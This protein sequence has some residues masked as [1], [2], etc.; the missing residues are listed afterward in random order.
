MTAA[1]RPFADVRARPGLRVVQAALLLYGL[2]FIWNTSFVIGSHRVFCLFEDAMISM[3][4]ARNFSK[5]AGLVWNPGQAPVEGYTN[6]LWTLL[7]VPWHWM[8]L[9][10]NFTS[11][12]VQ[13]TA[14]ACLLLNLDVTVRVAKGVGAGGAAALFALLCTAFYLPILNWSL[15][16]METG[17]LM[18]VTSLACRRGLEDLAR[19]RFGFA[20]YGWL[21][22]GTLIR[23]DAL[24]MLL[25]CGLLMAALDPARRGRRLL[26]AFGLTLGMAALQAGLR[27]WYYGQALPNTYYLKMTGF[28]VGLR[29]LRGASVNGAFLLGLAWVVPAV[30]LGLLVFRE[31]RS[32]FLP[33]GMFMVQLLYSVYVGGDAWEFWGGSNRFVTPAMPLLF[34]AAGYALSLAAGR[35]APRLRAR[36][37]AGAAAALAMALLTLGAITPHPR[38]LLLMDKALDVEADRNLVWEGMVIH[39]ITLPSAEVAVIDAGCIPY[40][41]ERPCLDML[42]KSDIHIAHLA[43]HDDPTKPLDERF[44]PGH[45]KWDYGWSIGK[46][47]P[48]VVA[49]A[50]PDSAEF[51]SRLKGYGEAHGLLFRLDSGNIDWKKVGPVHPLPPFKG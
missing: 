36:P 17:L 39:D 4:Y 42:G 14:L 7:M 12:P 8:R 51:L 10:T 45:L 41:S 24:A 44:M 33:L 18:L 48:D 20:V 31:M 22:A 47:R 26:A 11:L 9:P 43:M 1:A 34:V 3:R 19:G 5:G 6:F 27:L 46:F 25:G 38:V 16:G 2:A 15:L 40:F 37:K 30:L 13:L 23:V 50:G 21:L 32:A 28:P 29:L 35:W 49:Q